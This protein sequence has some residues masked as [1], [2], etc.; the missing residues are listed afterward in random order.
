M[1]FGC[2]L[3]FSTLEYGFSNFAGLISKTAAAA[4]TLVNAA[5]AEEK[6]EPTSAPTPEGPFQLQSSYN[7][8]LTV[9]GPL[10]TAGLKDC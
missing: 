10:L 3:E 9:A 6:A 8:A 1:G 2:I 4:A 5:A 7:S